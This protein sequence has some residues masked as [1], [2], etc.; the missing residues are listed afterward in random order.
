[1]VVSRNQ[2]QRGGKNVGCFVTLMGRDLEQRVGIRTSRP[3]RL[4]KS[5]VEPEPWLLD[6][7]TAPSGSG[8]YRFCR[9]VGGGVVEGSSYRSDVSPLSCVGVFHPGGESALSGW[10]SV[11]P[12]WREE[13]GL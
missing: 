5:F 9:M 12:K 8:L 3:R 13:F 11:H 10:L 7:S 4:R 2:V 1:M 6:A